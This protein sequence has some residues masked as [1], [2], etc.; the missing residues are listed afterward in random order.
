MICFI[1]SQICREGFQ[2][3]TRVPPRGEQPA[4]GGVRP[5]VKTGFN[6]V[7]RN[8]KMLFEVDDDGDA[9]PRH[10]EVGDVVEVVG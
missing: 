10:E 9:V 5:G 4:D 6:G 3:S 8:K 7:E 1:R 2:V